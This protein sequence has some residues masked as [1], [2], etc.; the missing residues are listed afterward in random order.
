MSRMPALLVTLVIELFVALIVTEY[1]DRTQNPPL[2]LR[3]FKG[4]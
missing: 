1:T 2:L 4:N 3:S